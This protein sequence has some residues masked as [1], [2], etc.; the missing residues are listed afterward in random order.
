[1]KDNLFRTNPTKTRNR[2]EI[3]LIL[4]DLDIANQHIRPCFETGL[5]AFSQIFLKSFKNSLIFRIM[6]ENSYLLKRTREYGFSTLS[7]H[8]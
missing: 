2:E 4:V 3:S 5:K 8:D 1:M 7:G 6:V